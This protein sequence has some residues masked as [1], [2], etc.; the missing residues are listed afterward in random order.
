M[1]LSNDIVIHKNV[2]GIEFLQFR[3]LLEYPNIRHG[4]ALKGLNFRRKEGEESKYPEYEKFLNALGINPIT[5]VKPNQTHSDNVLAVQE[6]RNKNGPDIYLEYLEDV[7][8][9]MTNRI[10]VTLASTNADCNLILLYD[11]VG[12]VIANIHAGW[13]GTFQKIVSK[14]VQE[15]KKNYGCKAEN[16]IACFCPSIRVCHFEVHEDVKNPCEEIFQY[17]N[18]L[19]E[20][21]KVGKIEDGKQ[22][23]HIDTVL[24]NKLLLMEEGIKEENILDSHICSVCHSEKVHSRRVEGPDFGVGSAV[25]H[26]NC[27]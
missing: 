10:H 18:R 27:K 15:M 2:N 17:T 12:N 22:K 4:Y 6:K 23:Y 20:I 21:I 16:I 24:I 19:D 1:N 26:L 3:K 11:T 14:T 7:D 9:T 5:L 25:I 13:R 8:A